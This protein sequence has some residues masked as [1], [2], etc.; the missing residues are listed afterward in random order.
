MD[1]MSLGSE[2][3]TVENV[4]SYSQI[5]F[6]SGTNCY[7]LDEPDS[8]SCCSWSCASD[9][10]LL[11]SLYL[12]F[13]VSS[14]V[15]VCVCVHL[16]TVCRGTDVSFKERS[17]WRLFLSCYDLSLSRLPLILGL[18]FNSYHFFITEKKWTAT[19]PYPLSAQHMRHPFLAQAVTS[20][21]H[22]S[23]ASTR[24]LLS[25]WKLWDCPGFGF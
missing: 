11:R 10:V 24:T 22:S 18:K 7:D 15:C 9:L 4:N 25:F 23:K 6:I 20:G 19:R 8:R 3:K 13:G 5:L 1:K 16:H 12:C 2:G 21:R 17:L 14:G